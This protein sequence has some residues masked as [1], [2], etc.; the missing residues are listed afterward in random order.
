V[1][2]SLDQSEDL[3]LVRLVGEVDIGCAAELK[4]GLVA[5]LESGKPVRVDLAGATDLDVTAL[6]LLWAAGRK[7]AGSG[8]GFAL[9]GQLPESILCAVANAGFDS[10]PVP[11]TA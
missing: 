10:F 7:A 5:A 4:R 11:Q 2:V 9:A 8:I 1:T 6:Q 3:C